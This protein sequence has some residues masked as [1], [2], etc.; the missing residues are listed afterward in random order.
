MD[1]SLRE[2]ERDRAK[3]GELDDLR[4]WLDAVRH[5]KPLREGVEPWHQW[6]AEKLVERISKGELS[7]ERL[8]LAAYAREEALSYASALGAANVLGDGAVAWDESRAWV[9]GLDRWGEAARLAADVAAAAFW[10]DELLQRVPPLPRAD[11]DLAQS[12]PRAQRI[13]ELWA[14]SRAAGL[15]SLADLDE[16]LLVFGE[17]WPDREH[18]AFVLR[19]AIRETTAGK[20]LTARLPSRDDSDTPCIGPGVLGAGEPVPARLL[21]RIRS[22]ITTLALG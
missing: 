15:P 1:E 17:D 4:G 22:R 6:E 3:R 21:D 19:H 7:R 20:P 2:F 12:L 9:R 10:L 11:F 13:V 5:A 14:R 16:I 18:A 8:A